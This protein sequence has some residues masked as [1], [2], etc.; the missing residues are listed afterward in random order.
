M[1]RKKDRKKWINGAALEK[2]EEESKNFH[3]R[4]VG[5]LEDMESMRASEEI[6]WVEAAGRV[7]SNAGVETPTVEREAR[8]IRLGR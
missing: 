5:W 1:L 3:E 7:A 2:P 4:A 8:R 6:S